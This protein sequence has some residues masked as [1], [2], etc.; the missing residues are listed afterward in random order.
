[1]SEYEKNTSVP[2]TAKKFKDMSVGEKLVFIGKS[3]IF[4]ISSGFAYPRIW[5]D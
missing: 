4:L 5:S 3:F 1:M 2:S